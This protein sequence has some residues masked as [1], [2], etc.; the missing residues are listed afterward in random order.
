MTATPTSGP[1]HGRVALVT[2]GFGALGTAIA[3]RLSAAGAIVVRSGRNPGEGGSAHDV[4]SPQSWASVVDRIVD[5]HGHLDVLVN[6]AGAL[7]GTD[8]TVLTATPG[9][10]HELFDTHVIGSWLGCREIIARTPRNPVSIVNIGSTAGAN[11]TPG[12]I[13][14]GAAKAAVAHLTTSV[15]LHCARAGL[16]VRCNAVAPALVDGGVRDDVLGTISPAADQALAA[17]LSRVPTGRL[18]R[19]EEV[20]ETV[21]FLAGAEPQAL[22]GQILTVA[23][24]LGLA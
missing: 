11:A 22:T 24:G 10:W 9:Q 2:G 14:Y 17:Y 21:F 15:A 5:E 23:G 16:S 6:S 13:A 20:A 3:D 1:M 19:P 18:V 7:G 4:T 8:Q 12:M